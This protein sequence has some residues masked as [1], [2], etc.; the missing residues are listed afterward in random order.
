MPKAPEQSSVTAVP[1]DHVPQAMA[2]T[3][4]PQP[5]ATNPA[6]ADSAKSLSSYGHLHDLMK[7]YQTKDLVNVDADSFLRWIQQLQAAC[8]T[9]AES[10][11]TDEIQHP[12]ADR[13]HWGHRHNFGDFS[14]PGRMGNHHIAVIATFIDALPALSRSLQGKRVLDIGC[15]T[16]GTSLLLAAMGAQ[17]V[18]IE[19]IKM[20]ADCAE[21]LC[22]AF[23]V[24]R[25]EVRHTSLFDCTGQEYQDAFDYVLFA[26]VLHH[27][28]DPKLAL[29]I[30]F[31]SLKDGGQCLLETLSFDHDQRILARRAEDAAGNSERPWGWHW[32]LFTPPTLQEMMRFVG[33]TIDHPCTVV[34]GRT[35]AVGRRDH[36]VD[37]RRS[38][39]S[40]RD[41]R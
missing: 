18:A 4:Q 6:I 16:G 22:H 20:Y 40:M 23:D 21:F 37:F 1:R 41:I 27:L 32:L 17:V 11:R 29:R 26:G 14:M 10:A 25:L 8:D 3:I 13:F 36:H 38:G 2:T 34:D 15:W 33:F 39:L 24:Q 28:S 5:A 12:M 35:F 30:V 19:E 31:N 9:T 7:Q